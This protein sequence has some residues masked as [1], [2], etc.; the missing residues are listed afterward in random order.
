M[1][2]WGH[3][4]AVGPKSHLNKWS[5]S[6]CCRPSK[7]TLTQQIAGLLSQRVCHAHP[8][9]LLTE[10]WLNYTGIVPTPGLTKK[11]SPSLIPQHRQSPSSLIYSSH[12]SLF[13]S[14]VDMPAA[15]H[16]KSLLPR[17]PLPPPPHPR[18]LLHSRSQLESVRRAAATQE[19]QRCFPWNR[20]FR[21][22]QIAAILHTCKSESHG[23]SF[24]HTAN[25]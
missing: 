15:L 4:T 17:W 14:T 13:I 22:S 20:W 12:L 25:L 16:I 10:W 7:G 9:L 2:A 1:L 18:L 19:L 23:L 5:L 21:H 11:S 24:L 6:N 3:L 8:Q